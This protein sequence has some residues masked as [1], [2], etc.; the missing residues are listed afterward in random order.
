MGIGPTHDLLVQLNSIDDA[1]CCPRSS[2]APIRRCL[3][4]IGGVN[5]GGAGEA[6]PKRWFLP[7]ATAAVDRDRQPDL[8]DQLLFRHRAGVLAE[9]PLGDRG[10]VR[11]EVGVEGGDDGVDVHQ[12]TR[13]S[14]RWSAG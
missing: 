8:L 9:H 1:G 6:R 3:P 4:R 2:A 5:G 13:R 14:C 10:L 11:V 12:V 7:A